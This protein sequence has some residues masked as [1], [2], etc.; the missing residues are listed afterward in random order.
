[1]VERGRLI[2]WLLSIMKIIFYFLFFPFRVRQ[3]I[4][5]RKISFF[6][7]WCNNIKNQRDQLEHYWNGG[8]EIMTWRRLAKQEI[9]EENGEFYLG[10]ADFKGIIKYLVDHWKCKLK[11][12]FVRS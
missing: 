1:M 7:L 5:V 11:N 9:W 6:S 4:T 2:K 8:N 12:K 10:H 3:P